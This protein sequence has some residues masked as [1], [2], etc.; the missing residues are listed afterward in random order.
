M[1]VETAFRTPMFRKEASWMIGGTVTILGAFHALAGIDE[2]CRPVAAAIGVTLAWCR[3]VVIVAGAAGPAVGV[4][5]AL[6][7]IA[8]FGI[9]DRI[10]RRTIR[11]RAAFSA[12]T[13]I[14][15]MP[16]SAVGVSEAFDAIVERGAAE[17]FVVVAAILIRDAP[18]ANVA[19][20]IAEPIVAWHRRAARAE[21]FARHRVA[22]RVRVAALRS[23]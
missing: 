11:V 8:V 3:A 22:Y 6:D 13:R 17:G 7:A 1:D 23:S 14:T 15:G 20:G 19:A 10:R 16:C 18:D 9:A 4:Y 12:V 2:T 5:E 21:A